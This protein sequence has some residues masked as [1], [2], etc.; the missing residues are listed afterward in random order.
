M[1]SVDPIPQD[2]AL[3]L[4][5]AAIAG[6]EPESSFLEIRPLGPPGRQWFV[7]VRALDSA[8]SVILKLSPRHNVYVGAAPRVRRSGTADA[9][10]HIWT[11]WV[12]CDMPE[13][14]Q[15]L[16]NFRPL[17]SI[18]I[19]SGTDDRLHA[20]WQLRRSISP[21]QAVRA[22]R[23]LALALAADR[24]ATDA[25][26]IMRP[27]GSLNHKTKPPRAVE[28]V[29]LEPTAFDVAD[30]VRGL[31]DDAAYIQAPRPRRACMAADGRTVLTGLARVVRDATIGGRNNAL[32][33][34]AYRAGEHIDAGTLALDEA[35]GELFAAAL[36]VGLGEPEAQRTIA[37]G[38][39][40]ATG[41]R[42]A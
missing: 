12:D 16:R 35:E 4:Q 21:E 8:A 15:R 7:P 28:C 22:N 20:W 14:V 24:A 9:V 1:A 13:A 30:V 25:A 29:R 37:S 40:A 36:D 33:W 41:R 38:L 11:L 3:R 27:A 39:S 42:A 18:V 2:G 31:E 34:A 5:L 26:R 10:E 17:P 32:N 19:R 23:R 6:N